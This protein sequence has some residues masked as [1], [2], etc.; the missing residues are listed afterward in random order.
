MK[1]KIFGGLFVLAI[2]AVAAFNVNMSMNYSDNKSSTVSLIN[3]EARAFSIEEDPVNGGTLPEVEITCDGGSSGT[4]FGI[5]VT[6]G[7]GGTCQWDCNFTGDMDDYC[8]NFFVELCNFAACW[9]ASCG[10]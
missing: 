8:S 9:A 7:L 6:E 4:C 1:K 3:V 5:K 2:A 10:G